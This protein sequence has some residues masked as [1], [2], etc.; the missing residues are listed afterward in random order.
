MVGYDQQ[1]IYLSTFK[2]ESYTKSMK[3]QFSNLGHQAAQDCAQRK[4]E[5]RQGEPVIP[6]AYCLEVG[7]GQQCR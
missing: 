1:F 6:P 2:L 3:Q 7:F 5:N 4:K